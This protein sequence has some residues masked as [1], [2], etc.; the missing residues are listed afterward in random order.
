MAIDP[1]LMSFV[2][3]A[4]REGATRDDI[5][6]T[7]ADAGWEPNEIGSAVESY[8]GVI[9]NTPVPRKRSSLVAREFAFYLFLF[10]TLYIATYSIINLIFDV[11]DY[12]LPT[13]D[14]RGLQ[15]VA[16]SI[17]DGIARCVV[18]V[19]TYIFIA[20][21]ADALKKSK[22]KAPLST[23][24]QWLTYL[25]LFLAGLTIMVNLVVLIDGFLSG[26]TSLRFYLKVATVAAI[27]GTILYYYARDVRDSED[28][29]NAP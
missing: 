10:A 18:F 14:Q 5:A 6:A 15:F 16:N 17:R 19:P 23:S 28:K 12:A 1:R 22:P 9:F 21:R 2:E 27:S 29:I 25:T 26:E 4:Y 11:L 7:L 3:S 13:A 24:Q 8:A 20:L